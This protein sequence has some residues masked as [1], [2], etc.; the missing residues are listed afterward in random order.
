MNIYIR[1]GALFEYSNKTPSSVLLQI[2]KYWLID[3]WN[4]QEIAVKLKEKYNLDTINRKFINKFLQL[5]RKGRANYIRPISILDT[6]AIS[7]ANNYILKFILS[8]IR[9]TDL[10]GWKW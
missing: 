4:C 6:L 7:N 2:L 3:E 5:C 8:L 10:G 1:M 9:W